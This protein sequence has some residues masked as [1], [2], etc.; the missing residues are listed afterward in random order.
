MLFLMAGKYLLASKSKHNETI[1]FV[2]IRLVDG[3]LHRKL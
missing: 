1:S 3:L 2:C